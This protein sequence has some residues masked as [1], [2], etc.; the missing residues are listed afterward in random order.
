MSFA[1]KRSSLLK[2][3]ERNIHRSISSGPFCNRDRKELMGLNVAHAQK[4]FEKQ[5]L[6]HS[7]VFYPSGNTN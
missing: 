4:A 6:A 5:K 1:I 2:K 3:T 7:K